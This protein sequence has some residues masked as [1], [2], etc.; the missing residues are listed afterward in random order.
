MAFFPLPNPNINL[1]VSVINSSGL[2]KVVGGFLQSL[3]SKSFCAII[4]LS[5]GILTYLVGIVIYA[6]SRKLR[7]VDHGATV[8]KWGCN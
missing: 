4:W 6:F 8:V 3:H 2:P 5:A 1:E 7:G